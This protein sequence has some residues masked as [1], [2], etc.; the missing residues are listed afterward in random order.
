MRLPP[1]SYFCTC[2]N[3][4]PSRF[5]SCVWDMPRAM[6]QLRTLRPTPTS[7]VLGLLA[8]LLAGIETTALLDAGA[9]RVTLTSSWVVG[10]GALTT[11]SALLPI[12]C[13]TIF[14]VTEVRSPN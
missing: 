12:T 6:R 5:P 4:T 8:D 9:H 14:S 10:A 3:E 13:V 11:S 7:T 1:V 2:W